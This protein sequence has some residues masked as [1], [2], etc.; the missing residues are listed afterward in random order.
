MRHDRKCSYLDLKKIESGSHENASSLDITLSIYDQSFQGRSKMMN[1][2][3]AVIRAGSFALFVLVLSIT[4]RASE[5]QRGDVFV[6]IGNG[7]YQVYRSGVEGYTLIETITDGSGGVSG[8]SGENGSGGIGYTAG[9]AF[10]STGHLHTTNFTNA[11]VY[12]YNIPDPHKVSKTIPA[13]SE[14]L[15]SESMVFDGQGNFFVGHADGTHVVD[16]FDPTGALI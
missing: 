14:A 1:S 16:K 13:S 7:Q 4:C 8:V 11:N 6:A 3:R 5:W 10:D 12:K 2:L 15:S 9:C